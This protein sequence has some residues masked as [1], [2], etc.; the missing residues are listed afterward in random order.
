MDRQDWVEIAKRR[1]LNVLRRRRFASNRQLDKKIAEAGPGD[2]RPEP[3]KISTAISQLIAEGKLIPHFIPQLGTFYSLA[4]FGG[5]ADEERRTLII[6]LATEFRDLTRIPQACGKA[7]ER[8]VYTATIQAGI[9]T[10]LGTPDHPPAQGFAINGYVLEKECDHILIPKEFSNTR[11]VVEDKNLREW[12]HP[13]AEEVWGVIGKALRIPHAIPVL[14]C[15]RM[16]YVGFPF[17]RRLG[18][19]CWQV[20]N[21][22]FSPEHVTEAQLEPFRNRDLLGFSDVTRDLTPPDPLTHF[23]SSTIPEN[24]DDFAERFEANRPLLAEY[25]IAKRLDSAIPTPARNGLFHEFEN[26][27]PRLN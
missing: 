24:I 6:Q 2:Q 14:I 17:F 26:L 8:V 27:L 21:Q 9:Y 10:V 23:F 18:M 25:A 22:F 19:L 1:I 16:H 4:D 20:Y 7:L 15:R 11:L 5:H 13:S 3:M 12:L